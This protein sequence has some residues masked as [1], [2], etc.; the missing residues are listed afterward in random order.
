M[1]NIWLLKKC[2]IQVIKSEDDAFEQN[3]HRNRGPC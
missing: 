1:R 3:K 2:L